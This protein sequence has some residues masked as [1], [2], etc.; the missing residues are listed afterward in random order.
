MAYAAKLDGLFHKVVCLLSDGE[1]DEGSNWEAILMGS[2]HKLD[3]LIAICDRNRLQSI[4]STEQTL[5]LE[6]LVDKLN[7]FGWKVLEIDGHNH[8]QIKEALSSNTKGKPLFIVANTIKGRGVKFME[9]QTL[10]HYR[11][12]RGE[13]FESALKELEQI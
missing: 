4:R 5:S 13:E 11:T 9:N 8:A 3:N 12:A 7:S 6:P 10:W 1:L 2:H